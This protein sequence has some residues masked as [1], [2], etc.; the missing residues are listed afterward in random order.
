MKTLEQR[1]L[2]G[3]DIQQAIRNLNKSYEKMNARLKKRLEKL[4]KN[5]FVYF[6]TFTNAPDCYNEL[7]Y[8]KYLRKI[9]KALASASGWV[10]NSDYG[11]EN[12]RLHFH[13]VA[14]FNS[15]LDYNTILEIYKYGAVNFKRIYSKNEKALREYLIKTLNH[16]TKQTASKIHYSRLKI[17]AR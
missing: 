5:E 1:L 4:L 14:S 2:E 6:I 8:N 3:Q 15:Q 7:D 10:L 12:G 16:A 9:K 17:K 11:S 13:A